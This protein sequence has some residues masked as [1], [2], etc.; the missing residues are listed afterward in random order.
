MDLHDLIVLG[1]AA[2]AAGA[3]NGAVGSGSLITLPILLAIGFDP[4]SA[5]VT[6]TCGIVFSAIGGTLRYRKDLAAEKDHLGGLML[7]AVLGAAL[8]SGILLLS[9]PD[10]LQVVVPGLIVMA[11]LLVALQ[12]YAV[13]ALRRRRERLQAAGKARV[14]EHP[15]QQRGLQVAMFGS[16]VYGGYFTAAQGILHMGIL[17]A[18]TGRT[19][20][21]VNG[22]K[23][24]L[25]ALI[26]AV[27]ALI[28]TVSYFLGHADVHWVA[29]LAIAVGSGFG[30]YVGADIAKRIPPLALRI[31]IIAVALFALVRQFV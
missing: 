27:A 11:I 30:G 9:P 29:S 14:Y 28:Y 19:P 12:P 8:G 17:G 16:A 21:E 25:G 24:L 10:A 13:A 26:N 22:V 6:N 7:F 23:N 1:V 31:V 2:V 18:F 15:Y 5:L 20:N 3:I 4:Q